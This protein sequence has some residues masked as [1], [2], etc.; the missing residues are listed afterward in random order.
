MLR[1][2]LQ[3]PTERESGARLNRRDQL[4][5]VQQI[6]D[7]FLTLFWLLLHGYGSRSSR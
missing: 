4:V 5:P 3:H 7:A 2:R 1:H 6:A